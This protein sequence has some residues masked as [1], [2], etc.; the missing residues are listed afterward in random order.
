M[1]HQSGAAAKKMDRFQGKSAG[2]HRFSHEIRVVSHGFLWIF[3]STNLVKPI[4]KKMCQAE[5]VSAS[6][7]EQCNRTLGVSPLR[8]QATS[9]L[10]KVESSP[11]AAVATALPGATSPASPARRSYARRSVVWLGRF[12]G[13]WG[14]RWWGVYQIIGSFFQW[15]L[16]VNGDDLLH[17]WGITWYYHVK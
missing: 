9:E 2:H 16:M 1:V 17:S 8:K 3:P 11:P 15:W 13:I 12:K 6:V 10:F 5:T 14:G 7:R 4:H